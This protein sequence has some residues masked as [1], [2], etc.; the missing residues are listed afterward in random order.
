M[1]VNNLKS[2]ELL[3]ILKEYT[4]FQVFIL[5]LYNVF[6]IVGK[7]QLFGAKHD[8]IR[9]KRPSDFINNHNDF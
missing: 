6:L 3:I 1:I 8:L 7:G 5:I 2:T 4:H 9:L